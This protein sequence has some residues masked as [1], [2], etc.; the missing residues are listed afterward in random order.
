MSLLSALDA[1]DRAITNLADH[2][3]P[4]REAERRRIFDAQMAELAECRAELR[5][6]LDPKEHKHG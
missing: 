1:Q 5:R 6:I 2:L 4:E 3:S